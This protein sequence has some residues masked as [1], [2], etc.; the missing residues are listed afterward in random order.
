MT[1]AVTITLLPFPATG[2][3]ASAAAHADAGGAPNDIRTVAAAI[4]KQ[5][6]LY[7]YGAMGPKR[8]DCSGLTLHAF[9]QAGK[10]LPRTQSS[11]NCPLRARYLISQASATPLRPC[12]HH[13]RR[14]SPVP[15]AGGSPQA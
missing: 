5:G 2:P 12:P 15:D 1:L 7:A 14:Y 13:D 6:A 11:W 9:R 3:L 4:S 10:R 8:F